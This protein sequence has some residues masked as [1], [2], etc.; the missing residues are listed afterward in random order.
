MTDLKSDSWE[1]L[2]WAKWYTDHHR[3]Q[4]RIFQAARQGDCKKLRHL[5]MLLLRSFSAKC[6]AVRK[7]TQKNRGKRTPGV[8]GKVV[9]ND[10]ERL[11]MA[12]SLDLISRPQPFRIVRIPK[13]GSPKGRALSIPVIRDRCQQMLV[14]MAL[15]PEWEACFERN[16]Y[17]YRPGR[18]A[19]DAVSATRRAVDKTPGG[20][21]VLSADIEACFDNICHKALLEKLGTSALIHRL[22]R[23]WLKAG[24][25]EDG[26]CRLS[27]Q[28]VAQ[29]SIL[30][31][32]LANIAFHGLELKI[33]EAFQ[34]VKTID[35]SNR[36]WQPLV[37]RYADDMIIVHRDLTALHKCRDILE[38]FLDEIGL[39]L[40]NDKTS[41]SHTLESYQGNHGF[42]FL[43]HRFYSRKVGKHQKRSK[44]LGFVTLVVPSDSAV[45]RHKEALRK[46]LRKH[47]SAHQDDLVKVL[48]RVVGGW[49]RYYQSANSS[50]AFCKVGHALF[51][52]LRQWSKRRHGSKSM[53]W[54]IHRYWRRQQGR[55]VFTS[56]DL[57]PVLAMH[58][59]F[60]IR[61]RP[62]V[63]SDRSP[64]DRQDSY[65]QRKGDRIWRQSYPHPISREREERQQELDG[66]QK[67]AAPG[68]LLQAGVGI[69]MPPSLL[70]SAVRPNQAGRITEEPDAL[71]GA[72]PVLHQQ[73]GG[74]SR[75]T[76][77]DE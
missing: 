34:K 6:L 60:R 32:L 47:R 74:D 57:S 4:C 71:K 61:P 33:K 29:G 14:K 19:I 35:G 52:M 40:N 44:L 3:L 28:G 73:P 11:E 76:V 8:D 9:V 64:F 50:S 2:P 36:S 24:T 38:S 5:Q 39:K 55:L 46:I 18:S 42:E 56:G 66:A 54:C 77:T 41:I 13:P 67:D 1:D 27:R 51:Q 48:N 62:Q 59:E 30:G 63:R 37:I 25:V 65:W 22:V 20:K 15:E 21:F 31:P 68:P 7:I 16:V 70:G 75:L 49:C 72:S 69:P 23:G 53:G 12:H 26:V 17:G 58:S 10:E 45:K 43:S